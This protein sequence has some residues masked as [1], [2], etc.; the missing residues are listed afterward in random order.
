[1]RMNLNANRYFVGEMGSFF[2]NATKKKNLEQARVGEES[3]DF[4]PD[5]IFSWYY[6]PWPE[7]HKSLIHALEMRILISQE[8]RKQKE[9]R[10]RTEFERNNLGRTKL[11]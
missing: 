11:R 8:N 2:L 10:K 6:G 4:S 3:I 7:K 5:P 9:K 1:M